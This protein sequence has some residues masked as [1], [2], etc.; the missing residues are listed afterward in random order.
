MASLQLQ[1]HMSYLYDIAVDYINPTSVVF[2]RT[3]A[4]LTS[5]TTCLSRSVSPSASPASPVHRPCQVSRRVSSL[6]SRTC[7]NRMYRVRPTVSLPSP[8]LSPSFSPYPHHPYL[9]FS[10]PRCLHC[11]K[12]FTALASTAGAT[13]YVMPQIC[14]SCSGINILDV[15]VQIYS[16]YQ[17]ILMDMFMLD[18]ECFL[19]I[20]TCVCVCECARVCV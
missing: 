7:S 1:L 4:S 11:Y 13:V 15:K 9:P 8:S 6:P 5:T 19:N 2:P 17:R 14:L 18:A 3:Q 16:R 12:W 10:H 20:H